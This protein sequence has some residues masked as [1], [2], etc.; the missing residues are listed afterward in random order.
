[1]ILGPTSSIRREHW[2]NIITLT[3]YRQNGRNNGR[4]LWKKGTS[5]LIALKVKKVFLL[6]NKAFRLNF[7][8]L[9]FSG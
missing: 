7:N 2:H 6:V 9:C 4:A 5:V 3:P 1:M 8:S